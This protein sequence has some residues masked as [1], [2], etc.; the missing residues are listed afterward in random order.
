MGRDFRAPTQEAVTSRLLKRVTNLE[1]KLGAYLVDVPTTTTFVAPQ[2]AS[3]FSG[4]TIAD[5]VAWQHPI[6]AQVEKVLVTGFADDTHSG[7]DFYIEVSSQLATTGEWVSV[8]S[9]SWTPLADPD[10]PP[11]TVDGNQ[12]IAYQVTLPV[13]AG[14]RIRVRINGSGTPQCAVQLIFDR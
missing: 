3:E 12:T 4:D 5:P 10:V 1:R 8:Y 7:F 9:G 11:G 13:E 14:K 2:S 6:G